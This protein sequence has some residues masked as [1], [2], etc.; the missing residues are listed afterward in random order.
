MSYLTL[1]RYRGITLTHDVLARRRHVTDRREVDS[2]A[3]PALGSLQPWLQLRLA[4]RLGGWVLD[5]C[6]D[7]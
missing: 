3:E 7:A 1:N 4:A 5:G 2:L 6:M